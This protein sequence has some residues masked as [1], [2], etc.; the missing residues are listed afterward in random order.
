MRQGRDDDLNALAGRDIT[1]I[2]AGVAGL[3]AATAMAQR[4][5]HV[6]VLERAEALR[7]V[8]AGL[9]ISPNAGRVFDALGLGTALDQVSQ[10]SDG[11]I[12]HDARGRVV[13]SLPLARRRPGAAFRLVH[14]ARL[15]E[16][17]GRA[18][19][20]AGTE[21]MLGKAAGADVPAGTD[22]LVG[23]D[24]LRSAVREALN[25]AQTP[26]FTGQI[27]WRALIHDDAPDSFA[28]VYMGPGQHLVS[29]RLAGGLR[30]IVA[31]REAAEW[32]EEGWSHEDD[33]AHLRAA[34]A[35]VSGP[36]PGWLEQV[37][38]V[39]IWGL[40]RHE[41]AAHWHDGR[42]VILGDAAH[43][44]LPFMAQGAVMAIEDAW[45]LA[46]CLDAFTDQSAALARYQAIRRP[47]ALRLVAEANANARN[48]HLSGA[49]AMLAHTAL[50]GA[51]RLAPGLL[52]R[53]FDWIYDY[54]PIA[55]TRGRQ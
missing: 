46:A 24:G 49:A 52:M 20:D 50:R 4:G 13:A 10:R 16:L 37:S 55:E 12:L 36:V 17:L 47:R 25:G 39:S 1:I 51:S 23:A 45:T 7:E 19:S 54:D 11:V 14:R 9:Q 22:L 5:A 41:V 31:V 38:Q 42:R 34:F 26:F 8:G 28:R 53:R 27:A 30:N 40:F 44:T 3:C 18:A 29:Y 21:I 32:H 35:G 33:P 2:G 6:R 43:P 48:Y 15:I